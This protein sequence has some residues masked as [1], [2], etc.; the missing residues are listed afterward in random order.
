MKSANH[1]KNLRDAA[2]STSGAGIGKK[3]KIE[4][5]IE[6][7]NPR[8]RKTVDEEDEGE[9]RRKR[10]VSFRIDE[11]SIEE[12]REV[13]QAQP[14]P[15]RLH[16]TRSH[17]TAANTNTQPTTTD[18]RRRMGR[19]RSRSRAP[20]PRPRSSSRLY[21]RHHQRSAH[22]RHRTRRTA[23]RFLRAKQTRRRSGGRERRVGAAPC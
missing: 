2:A 12:T 10:Q 7:E 13:Q 18:Q 16:S 3:R 5:M 22:L 4:E 21:Q 6:E 17:S 23:S 14:D 20:R 11:P 1:R 19:L 9:G 15:P 8:K